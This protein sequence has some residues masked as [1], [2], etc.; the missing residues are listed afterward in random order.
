VV[1]L[2]V[3]AA[4]PSGD[5]RTGVTFPVPAPAA[6]GNAA[7]TVKGGGDSAETTC[8]G[9]Y[10]LPTAPA[11]RVCIYRA[12]AAPAQIGTTA[13]GF[14]AAPTGGSP[15]GFVLAIFPDAAGDASFAGSWAYTAP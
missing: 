5:W 12:Y 7:V 9:T 4:N 8:S 2:D 3:D 14:A 1:T 11:G 15:Y 6:V 10:E 13:Q